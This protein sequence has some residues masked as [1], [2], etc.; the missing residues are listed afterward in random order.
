[1]TRDRAA[2]VLGLLGPLAGALILLL[3]RAHLANTNVAL[4]LVVIVVAVAAIGSR[5]A[6]ALAAVSAFAWFDF[7]FTRPYERFSIASAADVTTAVLLL[8]VGLAVS[9]L[10]ARARRMRVLAIT[11]AGYLE[12]IHRA[13]EL[14][15]SAR[16]PDAV[17]DHVREAL[18]GLLGLESC[19]FEYGSLLG[20]PPRLEP[21]GTVLAAHRR[22]NVDEFGFPPGEIELRAF[23]NGQYFGRFML[24]PKPGARPSLQARLVAAT[25]AD[26]TGRAL[27]SSQ[28]ARG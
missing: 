25:L 15:S 14:S 28:N 2:V 21:D 19:R 8:L 12:L 27:S 24:T 4:I 3:W 1:M 20:R 16:S 6:G 7:F 23:G 17:V 18:V 26:L 13:G 22:W 11:D 9:Q 10:A 5:I